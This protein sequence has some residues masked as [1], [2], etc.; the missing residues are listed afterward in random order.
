MSSDCEILNEDGKEVIVSPDGV[1]HALGLMPDPNPPRLRSYANTVES[2]PSRQRLIEIVESDEYQNNVGGAAHYDSTWTKNQNGWGKC[3]SSAGTYL[4]EKARYRGGQA[5]IEL[6]DDYLYSL[7]NGGRDR[8]STLGENLRAI[9][10]RGIASRRVVAEG[11]IYRGRYDN[12]QADKDALRFRGHEGIGINSEHEAVACLAAGGAFA[13]AVH[14]GRNWKRFDSRGVLIGDRGMGNHSEHA[15]HV[16]Y[17]RQT[18]QFEFRGHS[19]HGT[20]QGDGGFYWCLW[21]K[22]LDSVHSSHQKY[23]IPNAIQDPLGDSPFRDGQDFDDNP[24]PISSIKLTVTSSEFCHWCKIWNEKDRPILQDA[25]VSIQAGDVPGN[26]VPRF[27]LEVG[28]ISK[29]KVGYWEADAILRQVAE[30]KTQ[31][32]YVPS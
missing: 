13:Y 19:S 12:A 14:V 15:D 6:S 5:R 20:S 1:R 18:G 10:T 7:V 21:D 29:E 23:T 9:M 28:G 27:R 25:G 17:N 16:R 11:K 4:E 31:A 24:E 32:I 2:L 8:G 26:G 30:L 22:H 3:A